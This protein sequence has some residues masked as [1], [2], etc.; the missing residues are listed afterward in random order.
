MEG[1][2]VSRSRTYSYLNLQN[3]A[4]QAVTQKKKPTTLK[5]LCFQT[6]RWFYSCGVLHSLQAHL[7]ISYELPRT[8]ELCSPLSVT[9]LPKVLAT[10]LSPGEGRR[11]GYTGLSRCAGPGSTA[12]HGTICHSA[13]WHG[14]AQHGIA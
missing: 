11:T 4:L 10:K 7:W 12:W 3:K 9:Q 6:E 2:T 5:E 13:A 14:L 1:V 8:L